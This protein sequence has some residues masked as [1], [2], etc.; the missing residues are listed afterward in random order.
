MSGPGITVNVADGIARLVLDHPPVNILTRAVLAA[1]RDA[2]GRLTHDRQLRALL[3]TAVGPNF[4]A[5]ADVAEHLPPHHEALI[6]EFLDTVE[7]LGRF[8]LPVVAGVR[9]RCLGGGFEFVQP[10]DIIVAGESAVFGQPEIVLGVIPPAACALLPELVPAGIAAHLVFTGDPLDAAGA[11]RAGLVWRVTPD[12]DVE[13]EALRVAER[14][15]RHSAAAL[16][17]A[18]AALR[19]GRADARAKAM[20]DAGRLYLDGVMATQDA[21]EGLRAFTERR[22]PAWSHA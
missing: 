22:R 8:P 18:K 12:A 2:L 14:I 20:R 6:P 3:L 7:A 17:L 10:A 5:G 9:G 11:L 4:S 13:A 16:R 21:L 19:S 15:A 1:V